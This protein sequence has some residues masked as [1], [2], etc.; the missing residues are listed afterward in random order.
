MTKQLETSKASYNSLQRQYLDQCQRAEKY[1]DDLR[2]R[3]ETVR[4]LR[5]AAG[6]TQIEIARYAKEHEVYEDRIV[7]ME[8]ELLV[9]QQAHAQ[10]DEQKQENMLLKETIDR[11]RF[12]LDEMRNNSTA[13]AAGGSSGQSS[14]ANTMSK[15]LG[16]ELLGKMKGG[17]GGM[18]SESEE[19]AEE[20]EVGTTST[21]SGTPGQ[22]D[23]DT[24]GEDVI[25]TIITRKKR[26]RLFILGWS[27]R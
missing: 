17:W 6:L 3:E 4:S 5:E 16:Q 19:D 15:S 23:D 14:A 21:S 9:A 11:M 18:E 8:Q 25:Q 2:D 12:D 26:V 22:D 20:E 1:R 27:Y 24:E 7:H 10:L 13:G